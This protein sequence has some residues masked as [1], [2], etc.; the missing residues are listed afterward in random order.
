MI[1]TD[2]S[3][4]ALFALALLFAFPLL[5]AR[6]ACAAPKK[7]GG[8]KGEGPLP[9]GGKALPDGEPRGPLAP[10][11]L[12]DPGD[13]VPR[14]KDLQAFQE[15]P[16]RSRPRGEPVFLGG[17]DPAA[18][19]DRL[20]TGIIHLTRG[21][22][23]KA[24]PY[25]RNV[26]ESGAK[27]LGQGHRVALAAARHLATVL[28]LK[29][30]A[31]EAAEL[32]VRVILAAEKD[33]EADAAE[34]HSC[35]LHFAAFLG[36]FGKEEEAL[37][38]LGAAVEG[39]GRIPEEG[40]KAASAAAETAKLILEFRREGWDAGDALGLARAIVERALGKSAEFLRALPD[41]ELDLLEILEEAALG[42]G[43][44]QARLAAFRRSIALSESSRGGNSPQTLE[45]RHSYARVLA[46][47]GGD[48]KG[49]RKILEQVFR[50]RSRSLGEKGFD[51]LRTQAALGGVLGDLGETDRG[52]R[53]LAEAA[54]LMERIAGPGDFDVLEVK[55]MAARLR[56][57]RGEHREALDLAGSAAARLTKIAG[58]ENEATLLARSFMLEALVGLG[59]GKAAVREGEA[60]LKARRKTGEVLYGPQM[61]DVLFPLA[62]AYRLAGDLPK[63]R[64][65][66]EKAA[67]LIERDLLACDPFALPVFTELVAILRSLGDLKAAR[68]ACRKLLARTEAVLGP[69]HEKALAVKK[70]LEELE[71]R[72]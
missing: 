72:G 26:A 2:S 36:Q 8:R 11:K 30:R 10:R 47:S 68:Q 7:P 37:R 17:D 65:T 57:A 71:G 5:G 15:E 49:A 18:L 64:K 39:L 13:E 6:N 20:Q 58:K 52:M 67:A 27:V 4:F 1:S 42:Q 38:Q 54:R 61:L 33:P 44:P 12:F 22:P 19:E 45:L 40:G 46:D 31:A 14:G 55:A 9:G 51:T 48:P 53:L 41:L 28:F 43:D 32:W 62:A 50:E 25:L 16:P 59:E 3:A 63:A 60:V 29:G 35:R 21:N 70:E 69:G 34:F 23:E 24:E 66:A 56:L